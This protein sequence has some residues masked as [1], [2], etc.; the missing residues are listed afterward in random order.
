MQRD[1]FINKKF[2]YAYISVPIEDT[3]NY[4]SRVSAICTLQKMIK[5]QEKY[6]YKT[7]ENKGPVRN[8][9]NTKKVIANSIYDSVNER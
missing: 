9:D 8:A 6:S 5:Q 7:S 1:Y 4:G 2:V 3:L